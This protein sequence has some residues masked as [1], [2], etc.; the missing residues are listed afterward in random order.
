MT[1]ANEAQ[2]E[3]WNGDSGQRWVADADRRDAVLAPVADVLLAAAHLAPTEDVLDLGCGCG[4]TTLAAARAVRPGKVI[5]V[6]LSAPMLDL[7]R[8][9]AG[10]DQHVTFLQA[11]AQ[12]HPFEPGSYD[13]VISRFGTMFF[14]DPVASFTNV[15]SGTRRGGRLCLA[16]W[17]P[18]A[19]NDWLLVPGAALLRYGSLPDTSGS[20][21]GMFAQSDPAAV[22]AVLEQA[23]WRDVTVEPITVSLRLGADA[24][25]ATDYLADTGIARAVLDTIDETGRDR[26]VADVTRAP[27]PHATG[28]GV[29]LDAGIHIITATL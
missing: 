12:T 10:N 16:T 25:E 5:A 9:R 27:E 1:V 15:A 28:A 22:T 2:Y 24:T 11:D 3:A 23:G 17:Q 21:P 14:D 8:R 6:D 13:I 20:A 26:A 29:R 19:A 18:L 7:A 4:I